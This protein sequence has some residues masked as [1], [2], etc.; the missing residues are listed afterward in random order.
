MKY[1]K[2]LYLVGDVQRL[3]LDCFEAF[4]DERT[5]HELWTEIYEN[6]GVRI[7]VTDQRRIPRAKRGA[8]YMLRS[9]F[10][11]ANI[12]YVFSRYGY[13][14]MM[15]SCQRFDRGI[16]LL[17]QHTIKQFKNAHQNFFRSLE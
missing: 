10:A 4:V 12:E 9:E 13:E 2:R 8:P 3:K 11:F 7:H 17:T 1:P 6:F 16:E 15:V 5:Y 14:G